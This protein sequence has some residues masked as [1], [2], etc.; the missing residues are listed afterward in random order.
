MRCAVI[1]R[2]YSHHARDR[3]GVAALN[4]AA[5]FVFVN[6]AGHPFVWLPHG[7]GRSMANL[8]EEA[9]AYDLAHRAA[10]EHGDLDQDVWILTPFRLQRELIRRLLRARHRAMVSSI[11]QC[12]GGERDVVIV[13]LTVRT[14]EQAARYLTPEK[15]NVAWSRARRKLIVIGDFN[16][17]EAAY[18]SRI[19]G[20]QELHRGVAALVETILERGTFEPPAVS[21]ETLA[22]AQRKLDALA[23]ASRRPRERKDH[24]DW[25]QEPQA[26]DTVIQALHRIPFADRRL[27][28]GVRPGPKRRR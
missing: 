10:A 4:D 21:E 19:G 3:D 13:S 6:T 28:R 24:A 23:E 25:H 15:L 11:D 12:Q 9:L 14:A 2:R 16:A 20:G 22:S 1:V 7:H 17:L 18:S 27:L 26:D 5:S 8:F